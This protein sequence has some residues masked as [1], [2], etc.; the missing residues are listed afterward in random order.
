[1][2]LVPSRNKPSNEGQ[3][4]QPRQP[5]KP[6]LAPMRKFGENLRW[7]KASYKSMEPHREG[8]GG[9]GDVRRGWGSCCTSGRES[10]S[11]T[12]LIRGREGVRVGAGSGWVTTSPS[13]FYW[14]PNLLFQKVK[15]G[16]NGEKNFAVSQAGLVSPQ[17]CPPSPT[18]KQGALLTRQFFFFFPPGNI[19]AG[20][21][22]ERA[23][24]VE[25]AEFTMPGCETSLTCL[26][27][28]STPQRFE[29]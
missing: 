24:E 22:S 16:G 13:S 28:L 4:S 14:F 8:A 7:C 10:S 11:C 26:V 23:W 2:W 25:T 9:F 18:S 20:V 19:W 3:H 1:M 15:R 29:P 27:N 12:A 17:I 5:Q 6:S 21:S